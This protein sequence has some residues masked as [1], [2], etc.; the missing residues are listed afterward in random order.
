MTVAEK[1]I[2]PTKAGILRV[3]FLYTGQGESTLL[4]IP[5]GPST[6][7]YMYVLVDCDRD[8]EKNEIDLV[9]MFKDLFKSGG[10]IHAFINTHPHNDHIGGI[11]DVYDE[12]G[13]SEVWHSNHKP[14]PKHKEKYEDLKYVID[15]VGK[16]NEYFLLGTKDL[17]KVR[18]S[19]DEETTKKLGNIDYQVLSPAQYLCEDINDENQDTR[20]DRI[21][22]QCGVIKFTYG[23][24]AKSIMITGDSDKIAWKDHITEYHEKNLPSYVL[25]A[26][27]HGSRTFFKCDKDDKDVYER[28][29]E[30]IKPTYLIISAPKQEDS[31][32]DHPHDDAMELYKKHVDDDEIFHLGSGPYSVIVDIDEAGNIELNTDTELIEEYGKGDDDDDGGNDKKKESSRDYSSIYVGS[33]TTRLDKKPMG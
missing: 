23:K 3:V 5:T 8:K 10:K 1:I 16:K 29:I 15:K 33:Q 26:S 14:G 17:N 9:E 20:D 13:F 7:D 19:D 4:V 21:H 25:S 2:K 24:N 22:E 32:H 12:I 18:S 28:H 27:H 11:K 6:S 30:T 31:P